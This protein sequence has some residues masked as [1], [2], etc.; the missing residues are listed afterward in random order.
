M[1]HAIATLESRQAEERILHLINIYMRKSLAA[2]VIF[3]EIAEL[4][5]E[6]GSLE[7]V[8]ARIAAAVIVYVFL[9]AAIVTEGSDDGGEFVVIGGHSPGI[10]QGAQIF[11]RIERVTSG[12][13]EGACTGRLISETAAMSLGVVLN[14]FQIIASADQVPPKQASVHTH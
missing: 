6:H 4:Y 1:P 14:E 7:L 13:A 10:T 3:I 11:A 9:M 5:V 12:R 2:V 8:D